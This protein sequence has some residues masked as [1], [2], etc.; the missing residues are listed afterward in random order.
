P[1]STVRWRV[2]RRARRDLWS[3]LSRRR[4]RVRVPSLPLTKVPARQPLA[5]T[6][7][8]L[9]QDD[10]AHDL[11]NARQFTTRPRPGR[12]DQF[13]KWTWTVRCVPSASSRSSVRQDFFQRE[14]VSASARYRSLEA[15]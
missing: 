2:H 9:R 5:A 6:F 7:W 8:K 10:D 14:S 15:L 12:C 1:A 13:V 3:G 11:V 4:S